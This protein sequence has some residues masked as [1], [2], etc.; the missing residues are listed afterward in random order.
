M[1]TSTACNGTTLPTSTSFQ[2][3]AGRPFCGFVGFAP[4]SSGSS[5][6]QSCCV[7][8][9]LNG[10]QYDGSAAGA[11]S[12][13]KYE[14]C[15]VY[16]QVSEQYDGR[17]T[18]WKSCVEP[19]LPSQ[20]GKQW[21]C[22]TGRNDTIQGAVTNTSQTGQGDGR[23]SVN[24]ANVVKMTAFDQFFSLAMAVLLGLQLLLPVV[25]ATTLA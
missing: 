2:I 3:P 16:C 1:N 9:V 5:T 14:G 10:S 17:P 8:P 4:S 21:T 7:G 20:A 24:A 19:L 11:S 18:N 6:I 13:R 15:I 25:A 22:D 12:A 23:G